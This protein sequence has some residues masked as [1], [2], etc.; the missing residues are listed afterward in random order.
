MARLLSHPLDHVRTCV[1][2]GAHAAHRYEGAQIL[3]TE[4]GTIVEARI[5]TCSACGSTRAVDPEPR[6]GL[7]ADDI[8]RVTDRRC[9]GQLRAARMRGAA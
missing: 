3:D 8:L 4:E 2:C 6:P 5:V 1:A 7:T 9:W